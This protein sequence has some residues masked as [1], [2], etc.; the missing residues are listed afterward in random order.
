[1]YDLIEKEIILLGSTAIEDQMQDNVAKE[2]NDF[3]KIGIKLWLL[4]GD[5]KD[6]AISIAFSTKFI[7]HDY[8]LFDFENPTS[9]D[10]IKNA[11]DSHL[12]YINNSLR[13]KYGL[14][15]ESFQLKL[16]TSDNELTDKVIIIEFMSSFII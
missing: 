2:I 1:M 4:T 8:K 9:K 5:K 11:L 7:T 16:I 6:T 3:I 13:K 15:V 10:E 14:I 12:S